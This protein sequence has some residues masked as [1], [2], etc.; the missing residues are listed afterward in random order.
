MNW[1]FPS[2]QNATSC[3]NSHTGYHAASG[4][5]IEARNEAHPTT[6]GISIL[7]QIL[8]EIGKHYAGQWWTRPDKNRLGIC[9]DDHI[10]GDRQ[11]VREF[12]NNSYRH[13][14]VHSTPKR[15]SPCVQVVPA[16]WQRLCIQLLVRGLLLPASNANP[17]VPD[18]R[19]QVAER[20]PLPV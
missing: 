14:R 17:T 19:V 20:R 16:G 9:R 8:T 2:W 3:F 12:A 7:T 4:T 15:W 11:V 5:L 18:Q 13:K 6:S 10:D 1:M